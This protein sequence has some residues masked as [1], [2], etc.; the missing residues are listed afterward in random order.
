MSCLFSPFCHCHTVN[1]SL[2]PLPVVDDQKAV[3]GNSDGVNLLGL[4]FFSIAFGL[5]LGKMGPEGKLLRNFFTSLNKAIM[6][7]VS[8]VIWQV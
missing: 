2:R 6:F 8:I 1:I 4:L 3:P 7:L 5:V